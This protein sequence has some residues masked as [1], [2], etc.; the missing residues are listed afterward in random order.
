MQETI[1]EKDIVSWLAGFY[2]AEGCVRINKSVRKKEYTTYRPVIVLNNTDM[3]TMDYCVLL[4]KEF[5]IN[6][7]VRDSAPTTSR[8]KIR[9]IEVSRI[10][11]VIELCNL[12]LPYSLNKYDELVLLK[13]FCES[14]QKRFLQN[15]TTNKKLPYN[16]FEISLYEKLR[17]YK[18]HKKG[19]KCLTY[20]PIFSDTK[21]E[22]SW[23][24]LAGYT[25]G[26]GS[27]SINKRGTSSYCIGTTHP[28]VSMKLMEFFHDNNLGFYFYSKLPS[29]NHLKMCKLRMY[30]YFINEPT[31]IIYIIRHLKRYLVTK[32]GI[33]ELLLEYCDLRSKRKGKWRNEYEKSFVTKAKQLN[34]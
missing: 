16:S 28:I 15:N 17:K 25:D 12:L 6:M 22:I 1:K 29:A 10:T 31:D 32:Y 19:R 30:T 21:N 9:F 14:R 26:D 7:Y 34:L 4:L 5:D 20:K 24:W 3:E 18:A 27:F 33:A 11:K 13:K 2:D 23:S 8:K